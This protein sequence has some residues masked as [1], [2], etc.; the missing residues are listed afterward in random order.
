[1]RKKRSKIVCDWGSSPPHAAG[2][3]YDASQTHSWLGRGHLIPIS[4]PSTPLTA[5]LQGHEGKTDTPMFETLGCALGRTN[6][7][8]DRAARIS[9]GHAVRDVT[10]RLV[11][12]G[13]SIKFTPAATMR[14]F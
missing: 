8:E 4:L 6:S 14:T 9:V 12:V 1:M 10:N 11:V 13:R 7:M 2:G 3:A 5:V